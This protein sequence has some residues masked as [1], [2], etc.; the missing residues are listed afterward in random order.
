MCD[1]IEPEEINLC[2]TEELEHDTITELSA[3]FR[4]CFCSA[5][6]LISD[7]TCTERW[8]PFQE[9]LSSELGFALP[10]IDRK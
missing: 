3:F 2:L 5:Q 6:G 10:A 1:K 7:D 4:R 9:A 8:I